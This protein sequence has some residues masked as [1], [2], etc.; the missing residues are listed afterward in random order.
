M[1]NPSSWGTKMTG[2]RPRCGRS[3][4]VYLSRAKANVLFLRWL[5]VI[6]TYLYPSSTAMCLTNFKLSCAGLP[7]G[8]ILKLIAFSF[9]RIPQLATC[10]RA[11]TPA[12]LRFPHVRVNGAK[13]KV[14]SFRLQISG[15]CHVACG[16]HVTSRKA[17]R[18]FCSTRSHCIAQLIWG[19]DLVHTELGRW[20]LGHH[21][22]A[23]ASRKEQTDGVDSQKSRN[24]QDI[25]VSSMWASKTYPFHS[26]AAPLNAVQIKTEHQRQIPEVLANPCLARDSSKEWIMAGYDVFQNQISQNYTK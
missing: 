21:Y 19:M 6:C 23:S 4:L 20:V 15:R 2:W 1:L 17:A 9:T 18:V 26:K 22:R 24:S 11:S 16:C 14:S 3:G 8:T 13:R 12:R 5:D 10:N 25:S 7:T